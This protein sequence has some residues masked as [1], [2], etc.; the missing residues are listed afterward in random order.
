MQVI[1]F[2]K[3]KGTK[4]LTEELGISVKIDGDI[5]ILNYSQID[6]P[7]T[8]PI[9]TE[10]RS[11]FLHKD[12]LDVISRGFD[13]F[14]N[15]GEGLNV[16]PE[17]DW[18]KA[19]AFEK[20]DGSLIKIYWYNGLWRVAT[21]G[22]AFAETDCMGHGITF[23][24]LVWK[25]LGVVTSEEFQDLCDNACL[26]PY[27]TYLFE[28]TSFENRVVTRYEGTQL[29]F[30]AARENSTGA[31]IGTEAVW[32]YHLGAKPIRVRKFDSAE[33]C[34]AA[35]AELKNLEEGFVIYQD[36]I[37]VCKVKSPAYVAVHHIRGEGLNPKRIMQLVLSGEETEYLSYFPQDEEAIEPYIQA[38][39]SMIV[40]LRLDFR[41]TQHIEDQKEFALAVAKSP[42]KGVLF[43]AR[44]K[45]LSY[46]D[47]FN[48]QR[49]SYKLE[50]FKGFIE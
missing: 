43:T 21:R 44:S 27:I 23:R 24:E 32:C 7:K 22:T 3:E 49:D 14:L 10:C 37:P 17:I 20:M 31:Y 19:Q 6:S 36:G 28:L 4:A 18:S 34:Q 25:A 41:A 46:M 40:D 26:N 2:I 11:L 8:H 42:F 39:G 33:A 45:G 9:V 50:V 15:Y 48:A 5:M 13:R 35:A 16:M 38:Y 29:H 12:S 47:A 30:L 1:E